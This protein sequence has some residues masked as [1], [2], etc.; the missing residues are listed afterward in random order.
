MR[1]GADSAPGRGTSERGSPG[2]AWRIAKFPGGARHAP[3]DLRRRARY[4]ILPGGAG[5]S[6][7]SARL[8]GTNIRF[9][10]LT[11]RSVIPA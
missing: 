11:C 6:G 8:W 7:A 9:P 2:G 1:R 4:P 3:H 10:A 5:M